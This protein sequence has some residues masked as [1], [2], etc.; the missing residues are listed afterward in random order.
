MGHALQALAHLESGDLE[1]ALGGFERAEQLSSGHHAYRVMLGYGHAAVGDREQARHM[2][3]E[4]EDQRAELNVWLVMLAMGYLKLGDT[5]HALDLL[6][7]AYR[8]RGGWIVWLGVEPGLDAL[9]ENPR[10][11]AL[12]NRLGLPTVETPGGVKQ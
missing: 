8:E 10:F 7:D 1:R 6:E 3:R 12:M 9:R 4:I 5:E 11:L 2:L